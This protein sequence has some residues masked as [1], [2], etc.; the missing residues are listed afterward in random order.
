MT[1][2]MRIRSPAGRRVYQERARR[3]VAIT[4]L[5]AM[6]VRSGERAS[7]DEGLGIALARAC[8]CR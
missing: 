8:G 2:V 5:N 4:Y 7:V 6:I 1:A 3:I